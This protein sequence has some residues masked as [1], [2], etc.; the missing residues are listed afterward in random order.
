M[1]VPHPRK[2]G[3][4]ACAAD[5]LLTRVTRIFQ[6]SVLT[7]TAPAGKR[8]ERR[9]RAFI[10]P[11]RERRRADVRNATVSCRERPPGQFDCF[12]LLFTMAGATHACEVAHRGPANGGGGRSSCMRS[13]P[14]E[15]SS[16]S[17]WVASLPSIRCAP[18][19]RLQPNSGLPEFGHY[20]AAE[21]GYIRLRL[22]GSG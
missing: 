6:K 12:R 11:T 17:P 10:L 18:S 9:P 13:M 15:S 22:R 4:P 21:V 16:S 1:R 14:T 7:K 8:A 20:Y 5:F 2:S 19:P 3:E